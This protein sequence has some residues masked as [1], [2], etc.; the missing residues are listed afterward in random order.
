QDFLTII[1]TKSSINADRLIC[2]VQLA[3][4][5]K[6]EA[7]A[8]ALFRRF[9]VDRADIFEEKDFLEVLSACGVSD[10]SAIVSSISSEAV[11]GKMKE[12]TD[13]AVESGC[14]GAPWTVL[15]LEN[16]RK[17]KF[18]GSDRLH[19][20]GHMMGQKFDGPLVASL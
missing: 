15:T 1:Q 18:F 8:R 2:A 6:A 9:W 7:V 5:E 16:G 11:K 19:I 10:P 20:I 13:E 12:N 17:E 14:F 3:Q 4:P